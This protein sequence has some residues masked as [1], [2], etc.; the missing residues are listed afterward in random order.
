[1]CR[2]EAPRRNPL[3]RKERHRSRF[4]LEALEG[5]VALSGMG[6]IDD[7]PDHHRG[8]DAA[9]VRHDGADDAA[10]HDAGDDNLPRHSGKDDGAGHH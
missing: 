6:G 4:T 9:E 1:M 8:R 2:P 3:P 10:N 7:G 5:R